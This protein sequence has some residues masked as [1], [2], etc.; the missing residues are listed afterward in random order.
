MDVSAKKGVNWC[1]KVEP[2]FL[3]KLGQGISIPLKTKY[4]KY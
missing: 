2:A 3:A 4:P 1:A